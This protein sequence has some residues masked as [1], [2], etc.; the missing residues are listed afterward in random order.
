M[1]EN[2]ESG[3]NWPVQTFK[4]DPEKLQRHFNERKEHGFSFADWWSF[5]T[6]IAGVIGKAVADFRDNGTGFPGNMTEESFKVACT[7]ISEPLLKY[8]DQK[9]TLGTEESEQAY[10]DAVKAMVRFSENLGWWWD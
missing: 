1:S 7:E 4:D 5:D 9:F 3:I 2:D 8:A 6:Y 10:L